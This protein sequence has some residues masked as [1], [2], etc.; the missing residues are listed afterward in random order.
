MGGEGGQK[1]LFCSGGYIVGV[2]VI[3]KEKLKLHNTSIKSIFGITKLIYFRDIW[4]MYLSCG[5][6]SFSIAICH[7]CLE[8]SVVFPVNLFW[9]NLHLVFPP[10]PF[11]WNFRVWSFSSSILG[12]ETLFLE[13]FQVFCVVLMKDKSSHIKK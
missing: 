6:I 4:K 9:S 13:G 2:N 7:K 12:I 3:L 5:K 1:I 10:L 8:R 11:S